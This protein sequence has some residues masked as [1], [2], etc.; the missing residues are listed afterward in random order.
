MS[1]ALAPARVEAIPDIG[2]DVRRHRVRLLAV[3]VPVAIAV[4]ALMLSLPR[5]T[6]PSVYVFDEL[7]YAYTAGKYVAGEE[8]YSTEIPPRE[9]P[10]IE[11]THPPLAKLLIAG[12]ILVA[13]D[14]P[15]GWRIASVLFGV[16]GA[17]VAYRLALALTSSRVTSGV[18][19]GLLLMDGLYLVE[20]RTGMSNLFVLVFANAALLAF[21]RVLTVSPE[22]VG[23]PLL[24]T[25]LFIG[26][27]VATKWSGIVLAGLIGL[28]VCWRTF[29]LWRLAHAT[30]RGAAPEVRAGLG[31]HLLWAPIALVALPLT[32]YLASYLHFW[33]TGH[34]WDDLI[35]LH[36]DML[37]YHR[38]LGV[39]HDDSSPWWQ[40]PLATRGVWYYVDTRQREGAFV[41]GNGNPLLYWPMIVA[42]AWVVIDWWGRRSAALWVLI[43][44]F[45]G[46]WLPWALSPRGTFIYHFMP[47]V[48]L[49]CI[50]IALVLTGAW[51]RGGVARIV[52]VCYALA[53]VATFAWFYP[54][55][56]AMP[57]NLE[58]VDLRMWL[59]SW[60]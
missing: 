23:P 52:A 11:W 47:V 43:V 50:A 21:Y 37:A 12:G 42:V 31:D 13:G 40:W 59:D 38:N 27:G 4:L 54:L 55:Y 5:L 57:L 39:V 60:R 49:G 3:A 15:L 36:R 32:I 25:G 53:T 16:A 41:F 19:A 58:Q 6:T 1:T 45:F 51:Q 29:E 9:D 17:L 48:P 8:A 30:N 10:A 18:A 34:G 22:R 24:A 46:Q 2:P 44:G 28:V 26:L 7:Y 14:N 35:A 56:T 33:L 20:S